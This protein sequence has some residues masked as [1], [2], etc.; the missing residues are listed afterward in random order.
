MFSSIVA[1]RI[2]TAQFRDDGR[3]NILGVLL[4]NNGVFFPFGLTDLQKVWG[5]PLPWHPRFRYPCTWVLSVYY[6][7]ISFWNEYFDI[8]TASMKSF[9]RSQLWWP[10]LTYLVWM[11]GSKS[12]KKLVKVSKSQKHFLLNF[13]WNSIAQKTNEIHIGPCIITLN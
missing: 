1:N 10:S 4:V 3:S 12:A 8:D 11:S 7:L 6:G 5:V 13:N 9:K 2:R